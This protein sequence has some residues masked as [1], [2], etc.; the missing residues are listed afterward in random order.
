MQS[1]QCLGGRAPRVWRRPGL[2][3][4]GLVIA[5]HAT[6]LHVLVRTKEREPAQ[7]AS[8][9]SVVYVPVLQPRAPQDAAPARAPARPA[10][11]AER[12]EASHA[13]QSPG[14]TQDAPPD[15]PAPASGPRVAVAVTEETSAS[16]PARLPSPPAALKLE[17]PR[18]SVPSAS[19]RHPALRNPQAAAKPHTVESRI[20]SALAAGAWVEERIDEN[21][22]RFRRGHQCYQAQRTRIEQLDPFNA[23]V[24]PVPWTVGRVYECGQG[25]AQESSFK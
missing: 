1:G 25:P 24:R 10:R 8:A 2:V 9:R 23:S 5:F 14:P 4:M 17:L 3:V 12:G 19:D 6:L 22:V 16:A 7:Q 20:A 13:I 18:G 21:T 15:Q 11:L